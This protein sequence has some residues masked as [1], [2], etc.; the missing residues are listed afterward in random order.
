MSGHLGAEELESNSYGKR[1]AETERRR[2]AV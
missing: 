2:S 1:T